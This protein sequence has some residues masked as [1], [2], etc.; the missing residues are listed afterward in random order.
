LDDSADGWT[1][2]FGELAKG[3]LSRETVWS[4]YLDTLRAG[5]DEVAVLLENVDA[6]RVI[7]TADHGE[8]FGEWGLFGHHR[9]VP[10]PE[11]IRVPW[12]ETTAAD[13]ETRT[14]SIGSRNAD[15]AVDEKLRALGYQ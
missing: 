6:E 1:G 15:R 11:L 5:L 7:I 14:P 10:V 9:A 8:C 3:R 2:V 13:E 4:A 12:V